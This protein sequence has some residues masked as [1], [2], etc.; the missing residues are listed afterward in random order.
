[1]TMA[2]DNAIDISLN[3]N[4]SPVKPDDLRRGEKRKRRRHVE[5]AVTSER[6]EQSVTEETAEEG[7]DCKPQG[8]ISSLFVNNPDIPVFAHHVVKPVSEPV[9]SSQNFRDLPIHPFMI[10]NLDLNLGLHKLTTVQEK[11]LPVV[12]SGKD[13]LIRSQTGSGKTLAYALPIVE[14]LQVVRPKISRADGVQAVV[15]V[16][17]RELAL[18]TYEWF[19]K[20][21]KPFTWL[22]PGYLVGGEKRKA[23]KARLRKGITVLVGTPGR[24]LDHVQHTKSLQFDKVGWLVVDEADRLLDMGYEK[25][26]ASFIKTLDLQRQGDRQTVL[27]SATLTSSV[28]KLAGLALQSPVFIDAACDESLVSHLVI[29]QSLT[30]FYV[31]TPAKLRLVTLSA[32][33]IW[34][35]EMSDKRKMLIFCATQD[36]VDF[37]TELLAR[38][39]GGS[40]QVN[41]EFFKLHGN[42]T[43]KERTDV[44]KTFR[45]ADSGVLL[46]TDVAARGLDLPH[47]DWIVQ[48]T[49]PSSAADYVH[50]V[51]RTAR[52]GSA[53]AALL[54]LTPSEVQFIRQLEDRRIRLQ[55]ETMDRCLK[56]LQDA[57]RDSSLETAATGLQAR[58][59]TAVLEHRGLHDLA[60]K[61]YVSWVRFYASYPKEAR[62]AFNFKEVHLGHYAKSFALR[63]PPS[64]IGGIGRQQ[65]QRGRTSRDKK[66]SSSELGQ[67]YSTLT[68]LVTSEFSSGLESGR[69]KRRKGKQ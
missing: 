49:A 44:F 51:G 4:S 67:G 2:E 23:E 69:K 60:C 30:Q 3:I 25:D 1:M 63:D 46:C 27:L 38:V 18:Q 11:A 68:H 34:K 66:G 31:V 61:A 43:Q 12:L 32:F 16:P 47:V 57:Q 21:V 7:P 58:F 45:A 14:A 17:T 22:V 39:L 48:F 29:P 52:V 13:A 64:T 41:V 24:L 5:P 19:V 62:P 6:Q 36:M 56:K 53:G 50:R 40:A 59:E 37:H 35:C 10:S 8:C 55:E 20:L 65:W 28:K 9:F 26:V 42:M 15:V 33:V 54:F